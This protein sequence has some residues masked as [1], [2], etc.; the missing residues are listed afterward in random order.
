MATFLFNEIIFGPVQSRRLGM[1]L[2]I[3][4]LPLKNKLCNF[5]CIYCECG[6]TDKIK[7]NDQQILSH[8]T[9][10]GAL[11]KT[12]RSFL[13]S[14]KLIDTITFAG[15]GEP[16]LHPEF[17]EII[18]DTISLR[19]LLF[20][21]AG[22]AVLSN[23]TLIGRQDIRESLQKIEYN[24]LK[25]DSS[26]EETIKGI[27]CPSGNFSLEKLIK[28]LLFFDKNLTL[29]TLFLKGTY[30]G[31]Y[32]D[33]SSEREVEGLLNIYRELNPKLVMIYTIARDTPVNTVEK[34]DLGRLN[35]IASR[36]EELGIPVQVSG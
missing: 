28:D 29:Q 18:D 13:D 35:K 10:L 9:I 21:N 17:S 27:N 24:I 22:I 19:D 36:V 30:N 34:I 25:I 14:G 15:N 6:F 1:S 3:N 16:T 11:E 4:L 26:F 23:A 7:D 12:L 5:N 32:F 2:G 20:P 33:N 8:K 31:F